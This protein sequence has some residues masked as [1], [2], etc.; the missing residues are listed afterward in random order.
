MSNQKE[1][2]PLWHEAKIT[3]PRN[4]SNLDEDN[5]TIEV[6]KPINQ[7]VMYPFFYLLDELMKD[8]RKEEEPNGF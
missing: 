7:K 4:K 5:A 6:L 3:V 2:K 1:E 8:I